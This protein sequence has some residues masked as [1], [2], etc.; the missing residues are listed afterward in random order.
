MGLRGPFPVGLKKCTSLTG[1]DLSR[2]ELTGQIPSN[3][4]DILPFITSLDLSFNNFSGPIPPSLANCRNINV[5]KLDHNQL[6]GQIPQE[7]SRLYRIKDFNVANNSLWGPVPVFSDINMFADNYLGNSGLCGGPLK[8]WK[9]EAREDVFFTGFKIGFAL[10]AIL[11]MSIMFCYFSGPSINDMRAYH[12]LI[13]KIKG[14]KH[15]M[16]T[17]SPD[18]PIREE[19]CGEE[20]KVTAME[21]FI[22]RLTLV[23]L[24]M[25]TNNFDAKKVIGYGY[26]GLMYKASFPNGLMLADKRLHKF[27]SFE[28]E[29]LLLY[30]IL[31]GNRLNIIG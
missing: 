7:L 14:R 21:K 29:F 20:T 8:R 3:I 12:Y 26:M 10:S 11:T 24:E 9:N 23:E 13:K 2:N 4:G 6:T 15:H 19:S 27:E 30:D 18:T 28:K 22:C 16:V 17:G 25:A 1:L 5:F 31:N